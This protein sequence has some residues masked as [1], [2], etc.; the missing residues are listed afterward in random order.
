MKIVDVIVESFNYKSHI[1]RDSEGHTHPGPEHDAT[2]TCSASSPTR[3]SRATAS[4]RA[5]A[6][7]SASSSRSC[8]A[9]I[10]S[11]VSASGSSSRSGSGS[12]WRPS[13]T[14]CWRTWTWRCG[15]SPAA[16]GPAGLQAAGRLPGQGQG[17]CQHDVRRR[18][19][20]RAGYAG[21]LRPLRAPVQGAGLHRVQA[22]HLAAA[23]PR[24]ARRQA[25]HGRVRGRARGGRP[26]HGADARSVPLL[27]PG[28]GAGAGPRAGEAGLLLDGRAD[29]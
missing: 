8:S 20:G 1:V 13:T 24:R 4:A 16:P 14:A 7:S 3:A 27:Q 15:I 28:G 17:L 25:R 23:H 10:R 2:Q 11:T 19:A 5:A 22:A 18:P 9:R 6:P 29:G 12:T 21:G 26:G